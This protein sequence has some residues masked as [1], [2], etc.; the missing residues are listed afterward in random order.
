MD[1]AA[2]DGEESGRGMGLG[3]GKSRVVE[4]ALRMHLTAVNGTW[5]S[6]D[7]VVPRIIILGIIVS[8]CLQKMMMIPFSLS[9]VAFEICTVK[10]SGVKAPFPHV[11][12]TKQNPRRITSFI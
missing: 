8:K 3:G 4:M 2:G 9:P 5:L 12:H 6:G 11:H 10:R 7:C 1:D